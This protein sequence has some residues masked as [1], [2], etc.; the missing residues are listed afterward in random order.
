M[1]HKDRDDGVKGKRSAG[2][3]QAEEAGKTAGTRG[4]AR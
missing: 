1:A 2:Y 4:R 3:M